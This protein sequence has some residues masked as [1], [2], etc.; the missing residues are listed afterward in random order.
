MILAE[1]WYEIYNGKFLTIIEE[2]KLETLPQR[3]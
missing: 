3:I 1:I 2:L